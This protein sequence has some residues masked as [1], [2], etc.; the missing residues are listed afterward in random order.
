MVAGVEREVGRPHGGQEPERTSVIQLGYT[1]GMW[2]HNLC[3]ALFG[4]LGITK[5]NKTGK[6]ENGR[7]HRAL[8]K[9]C[10]FSR[11]PPG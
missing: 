6:T 3:S 9:L 4:N 2:L 5:E 7:L 10:L 8:E 11:S 1:G